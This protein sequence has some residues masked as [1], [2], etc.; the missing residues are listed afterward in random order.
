MYNKYAMFWKRQKLLIFS[1]NCYATYI[2]T[3]PQY[4]AWY[5]M[6]HV[7][8]RVFGLCSQVN[9]LK[10]IQN[11]SEMKSNLQGHSIFLRFTFS[12]QRIQNDILLSISIYKT[13]LS[14]LQT[15][16][17]FITLHTSNSCSW[18][19]QPA[20]TKALVSTQKS[21]FPF[22]GKLFV[23]CVHRPSASCS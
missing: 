9:D 17:G 20:S 10:V 1:N 23:S 16:L 14:N 19:T 3:K 7:S 15:P 21:C 2:N 4:C 11:K 5:V 8:V 22:F 12:F 18:I 6:F 13:G